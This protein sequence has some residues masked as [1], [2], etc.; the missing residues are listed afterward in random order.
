MS[1]L[2]G[3]LGPSGGSS[4][5]HASFAQRRTSEATQLG[6]A[7]SGIAYSAEVAGSVIA[8]SKSSP[9]KPPTSNS[10]LQLP[11]T[12]PSVAPSLAAAAIQTIEQPASPSSWQE[13][14]DLLMAQRQWADSAQQQPPQ[15]NTDTD[16]LPSL[17]QAQL[18]A[19]LTD[20]EL[21]WVQQLAL[22][23]QEVRQ[24]EQA[25]MAVAGPYAKGVSYDYQTGPDGRQY[26]VAGK[27]G[28][29]LS[30]EA[31]AEQ[32]LAKAERIKRAA[33]A[34][35]QPS[36]QDFSVA[37]KASQMAS[38]ARAEISQQQLA[39]QMHIMA[40]QQ[41]AREQAAGERA[42]QAAAADKDDDEQQTALDRFNDS[43]G[44]TAE[45][46]KNLLKMDLYRLQTDILG[47][48]LDARS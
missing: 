9:S 44:K 12:P 21:A 6:R 28:I 20:E 30:S 34:P 46:T 3:A 18:E 10:Q 32:T 13:Q 7:V 29:D 22:R 39:E 5:S 47:R 35:A 37:A 36:P 4:Q 40:E 27:V 31:T 48:S 43:M 19:G 26:A 11:P 15:V 23:D 8:A 17:S 25:H 16:E 1:S 2:D 14:V 45:L 42:E 38:A 33:L 41:L 24:H